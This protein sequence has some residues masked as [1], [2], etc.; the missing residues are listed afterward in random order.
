MPVTER[1]SALTHIPSL[2]GLRGIAVLLVMAFHAKVPGARGGFLGVDVFFVLSGYLVV[3]LL[4][5]EHDVSGGLDLRRFYTRRLRRI[6]PALVVMLAAYLVLTPLLPEITNHAR[7]ALVS[8]TFLTDYARG[9]WKVPFLQ[10]TWSVA[11]EVRFY[12]LCAPAVVVLLRVPPAARGWL[13]AGALVALVGWRWTAGGGAS[14]GRA[15]LRFD[16]R[17]AGLVFGAALGWWNPRFSAWLGVAGLL[18]IATAVANTSFR[19][20]YAFKIWVPL[21]EVGAAAVIAS[22]ERLPALGA[23]PLAW[24]GRRSYGIYLWHYPIFVWMRDVE[25]LHWTTTIFVGGAVTIVVAAVSY[26]AVEARFREG[27]RRR[28]SSPS[29]GGSPLPSGSNP[30]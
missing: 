1:T 24:L 4:R 26:R 29:A 21:A 12:L 18:A 14:W 2:D 5:V 6:F 30:W 15:Y 7:D 11:M 16:L 8:A 23:Q 17:V 9:F 3:R 13:I 25:L 28:I 19:D 22:A 20:P 27:M 10:H